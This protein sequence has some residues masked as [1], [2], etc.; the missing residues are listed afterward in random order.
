[1]YTT[2]NYSLKKGGGFL[3]GRDLNDE[4]TA[5]DP[6]TK[7]KLEIMEKNQRILNSN[8]LHLEFINRFE[9]YLGN[10]NTDHF[11]LE[12]Y[13]ELDKIKRE[14]QVKTLETSEN[15]NRQYAV[16]I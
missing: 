13:I 1:M 12:F 6:L 14:I 11:P 9:S 2:I 10:K 4:K 3:R 7:F 8:L 16:A 15:L 5:S